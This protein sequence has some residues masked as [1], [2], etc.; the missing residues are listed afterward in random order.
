MG[1]GAFRKALQSMFFGSHQELWSIKQQTVNSKIHTKIMVALKMK[2]KC[3]MWVT[4]III[5]IK[6]VFWVPLHDDLQ[7]QEALWVTVKFLC[8]SL[9]LLVE[10][11]RPFQ[12]K[13]EQIKV[14]SVLYVRMEGHA[15]ICIYPAR[16][17]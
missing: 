12:Q 9:K 6:V 3:Q 14:L 10:T 5:N 2:F 1:L 8:Q 7:K 17:F 13:D 4:L 11:G 16:N 15:Y